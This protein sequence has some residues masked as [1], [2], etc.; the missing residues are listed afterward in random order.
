[1]AKAASGFPE[2]GS[3]NSQRCVAVL[4]KINPRWG[5]NGELWRSSEESISFPIRA[6]LMGTPIMQR[7]AEEE[8]GDVERQVAS[9]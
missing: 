8:C 5:P 3:F 7:T 6:N 2:G 4:G 1:M 9:N